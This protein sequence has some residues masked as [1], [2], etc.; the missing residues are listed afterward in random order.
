MTTR[1]PPPAADRD[2]PAAL[3]QRLA[4][5]RD[6]VAWGALLTA[7]GGDIRAIALH[8]TGDALLAEDV[9]QEVLLQL[10]DHAGRFQPRSDD[11]DRDARR[12]IVGVAA[13]TALHLLR[14][15]RRALERERRAGRLAAQQRSAPASPLLASERDDDALLLRRHVAALPIHY[16]RAIVGHFFCQ[17]DLPTLAAELAIPLGTAKSRLARGLA[18][19]RKRL[20][21]SGLALSAAAVVGAMQRAQALGEPLHAVPM[22]GYHQ[23]L[24]SPSVPQAPPLPITASSTALGIANGVLLMSSAITVIASALV[25]GLVLL[26]P[27]HAQEAAPAGAEL[28]SASD[29][30][31]FSATSDPFTVGPD[32]SLDLADE[33]TLE[34]WVRPERMP[35]SGGRIIDHGGPGDAGYMLDTYPGDSLRL[36]AG[37]G[38]CSFDAKLPSDHASH[39]VGVYSASKRVR[40]LYIDGKPVASS[41]DGDFPPMGPVEGAVH[42]GAN[43]YDGDHFMGEMTAVAIYARALDD[44]EVAA[45]AAGGPPPPGV[46]AAWRLPPKRHRIA[47]LAGTLPL[48]RPGFDLG[49]AGRFTGEARR[50]DAADALWYRQPA[51]LWVEAL[52]VGC[53]RLGAMDFGG[54]DTE[55]IQFNEGTVWTG[56]PHAYHREDGVG[57]LAEMRRLLADGKQAEAMAVA[58]QRFMGEPRSQAAFEPCGDLLLTCPPRAV[59]KDYRRWLDLDTGM[60]VTEFRDGDA[61]IR[62]EVVASYPDRLI[63]VRLS[64]DKPG[65]ITGTAALSTPH[66]ERRTTVKGPSILLEGRVNGGGVVRFAARLQLAAEGGRVAAEGDAVRF[67]AADAV[68]IR[69]TAASDVR[70]WQTVDGDPAAITAGILAA[71][72]PKDHASLVAAQR[73]DHQALYRAVHL[74]LGRSAADA[75][76]TDQRLAAFATGDDPSLVELMFQYGRY[77]LIACSRPGGQ[78]ATLQGIWNDLLNPPWQSKMTSNIN[79]QMNYWPAEPTGLPSC[80]EPLLAAL[81]ELMAS[82]ARTAKAQYGARGWVLHHN[83]DI[84]RGTAPVDGAATG[85]W[86][87]GGAW[88]A[89]HAW[90]HWLFTRDV[91]HLRRDWPVLREAATFFEDAL[92]EDP[93]THTLVTGPS[94]SPEHGGMVMGPTM[95]NQIVRSL[96]RACA[97]GAAIVGQDQQRA[98]TWARLA[99]RIA[100]NRI[101]KHGQLQEW[102]VDIDDPRDQHRHVSHLWGVHPGAD[103]T[104]RQPELLAAARQSLLFRGDEATGWSM[105][106]K[107]NLWARFLDGDHALVILRNLLRPAIQPDG[108]ERSGLYPNLFDA[109][110]PFQIDGNFGATAGVAEMLLQSHV[111]D[112][113]GR[114]IV[115]L[116][117][118]LPGGWKAGSVTGLRARG[119]FTVDIAWREGRLDHADITS[120]AGEPLVVRL[121]TAIAPFPLA[122][123][124]R[125]RIRAGPG[126]MPVLAE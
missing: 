94:M 76:P 107:I 69:L 70:D 23:L 87:T 66:R 39:V 1:P 68:T 88:L 49:W 47:A 10:R 27:S 123:A 21:R 80:A 7:V 65:R 102:M 32:A 91:D 96:L 97:E 115:H 43:A 57:A 24:T 18:L 29:G 17:F 16:Q 13:N 11:H 12:W 117:P 101:G 78:P 119:G 108:Q 89:Q 75:L 22:D 56:K 125:I 59:V 113:Q 5:V 54:I 2:G 35:Q 60:A 33:V 72:A 105:G 122:K 71:A 48:V 50:P 64:A 100:P 86:Q 114:H 93:A 9:V 126:G 85:L 121:G 77:L 41:V 19:L 42:I 90:E 116:L 45:R 79:V 83:F 14:S 28:H 30:A 111:R 99:D 38:A 36:I 92:V 26:G 104:W 106:W 25:A 44:G 3:L 124:Q 20:Q 52:P 34:A 63:L 31:R 15:Q 6:P 109:H 74:D 81:P 53:G 40:K 61:T 58:E 4:A 120:N 67:D 51:A 103:I 98:A 110:P 55:R 62:R 73:A 37:R 118:A 8:V 84:W 112:D 82:G 95:D 46:V